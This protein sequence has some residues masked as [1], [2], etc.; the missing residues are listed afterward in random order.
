MAAKH[1]ASPPEDASPAKAAKD[2]S[3]SPFAS[4]SPGK[5]PS[6]PKTADP[7]DPPGSPLEVHY[8]KV[9]EQDMPI[10]EGIRVLKEAMEGGRDEWSSDEEPNPRNR[11]FKMPKRLRGFLFL[12]RAHI[13]LKE[14]SGILNITQGLNIDRLKG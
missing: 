13:P 1:P 11:K 4:G 14:H 10:D 8:G 5:V 2:I 7:N 6:T 12:E 3:S 9:F